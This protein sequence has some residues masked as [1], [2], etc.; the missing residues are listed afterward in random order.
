MAS[1]V[2]GYSP[3]ARVAIFVLVIVIVIL[4]AILRMTLWQTKAPPTARARPL[5]IRTRGA[6]GGVALV[7]RCRR[8]TSRCWYWVFDLFVRHRDRMATTEEI[9]ERCWDPSHHSSD[10][11]W[12]RR[13]D[14][15]L[16]PRVIPRSAALVL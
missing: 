9:L 7:H 6:E 16:P 13:T 10:W 11:G 14:R 5:V 1:P 15:P 3:S 12:C 4:G 2:S 8:A